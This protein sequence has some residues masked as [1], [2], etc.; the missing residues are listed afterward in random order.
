MKNKIIR[1]II[2]V[3][4]ALLLLLGVFIIGF[5]GTNL[6]MNVITRHGKEVRVPEITGLQFDVARKKCKQLNLYIEETDRQYNDE[7]KKNTII[8]QKPEAGANSKIGRVI[9]VI[10]SEGPELVSVPS[11]VNMTRKEARL[12]LNNMGLAENKKI[13]T[14]YSEDVDNGR[15]I[16]TQPSSESMVPK[17]TEVTLFISLGKLPDSSPRKRI[18]EELLDNV[19]D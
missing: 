12:T 6:V 3:G 9:E 18:H 14:R 1:I 15:I 11:L 17:G 4:G 19:G 5:V 13:Q 8:T 7:F 10:V 2:I 16:F